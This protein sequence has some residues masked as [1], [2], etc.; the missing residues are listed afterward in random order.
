MKLIMFE[1]RHLNQAQRNLVIHVSVQIIVFVVTG[2]FVLLAQVPTLFATKTGNLI[3]HPVTQK[4]PQNIEVT[5][6]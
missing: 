6:N 2:C 5:Q 1:I 3:R 4:A